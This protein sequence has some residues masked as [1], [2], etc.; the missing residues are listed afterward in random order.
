MIKYSKEII[1][2]QKATLFNN[3]EIKRTWSQRRLLF[4][5]GVGQLIRKIYGGKK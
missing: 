1:S 4:R 3:F 5:R 2:I